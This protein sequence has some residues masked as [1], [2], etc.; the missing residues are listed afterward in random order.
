MSRCSTDPSISYRRSNER[1]PTQ[2]AYT[3]PLQRH[4]VLTPLARTGRAISGTGMARAIFCGGTDLVSQCSACV[5]G[6][7]VP[8]SPGPK[9]NQMYEKQAMLSSPQGNQSRAIEEH[10]AWVNRINSVHPPSESGKIFFS[11]P[12]Q[13]CK[14]C[15]RPVYLARLD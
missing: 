14:P 1:L 11:I 5:T 2:K 10:S 6:L 8:T 7:P 4:C 3:C 9:A 12:P 13:S 15:D